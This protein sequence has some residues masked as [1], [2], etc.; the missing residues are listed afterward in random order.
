MLEQGRDRLAAA[1]SQD[2]GMSWSRGADRREVQV[3]REE[4]PRP[5][6]RCSWGHS[7]S[8]KDYGPQCFLPFPLM[9]ICASAKQ[10]FPDFLEYCTE[11]P[12]YG[13]FMIRVLVSASY[14]V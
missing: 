14:R 10:H 13:R 11:S 1:G 8:V 3:P 2:I 5:P 7:D 4:A 6:Q 9:D 12:Q